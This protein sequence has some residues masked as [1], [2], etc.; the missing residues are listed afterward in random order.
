[1]SSFRLRPATAADAAAVAGVQ[2]SLESSLYGLTTYSQDDLETEWSGLDLERQARVLV[3]GERVVGYGTLHDRGE[4][5]RVE[6]I[7]HPDEQGRGAGRELAGS[8]EREAAEGGAQRVQASAFE[9]DE[10]GRRLLES[11]GYRP[12]RVF[13]ELRIELAE[14][15]P[16]PVWPDG[17]RV[18]GFDLDRDARAFHA[19][20]QEAFADHWEH[21]P[22]SFEDWHKWNVEPDSFDPSL[23]CVVRDGD[24][25]AAGAI[26]VG[27]LYGGGWVA[28]L[29]TRRP[30][31]R[32]GVGRALLL[33]AFGRFWER[34]ERS[35][36]LGVDAASETGAFRVYERAGM[37]PVLGWVTFEKRLDAGAA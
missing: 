35:V 10:A 29:F 34:G 22:R 15:P 8:L 26:N 12:V 6:G 14:P 36:G 13:R 3:D 17:L 11:I 4:L 16:P 30:W 31:R 19:A 32:R 24:E 23:W 7:V 28:V 1:M 9:R 33:D 2:V 5:W 20:H 18:D 25:I 21:T 37:K 27:N